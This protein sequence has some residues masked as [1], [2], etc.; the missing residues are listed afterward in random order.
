MSMVA[1]A[2]NGVERARWS[3]ERRGLREFRMK[4]E[5]TWCRLLFIGSKISVVVLN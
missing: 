5:M 2:T 4:S 3:R 1:E